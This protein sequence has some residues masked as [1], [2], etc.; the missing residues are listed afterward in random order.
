MEPFHGEAAALRQPRVRINVLQQAPN[1]GRPR[2]VA[3]HQLLVAAR[4]T[5]L[6]DA[7]G[8]ALAQIDPATLKS[9]LSAYI[10]TDAQRMLAAAGIRDEHVFP[11]PVILQTKPALLGY[12]RLLLGVPQKSF[13][14]ADTGMSQFKRMEARGVL[15][16]SQ[17]TL[18]PHL[19]RALGEGLADLVRQMSPGITQ[20]DVAELPLLTL[21]AQFQGSNNNSI[22]RQAVMDAFLSIREIVKDHITHEQEGKISVKNSAGRTV[23]IALAADPDVRIQEEFSAPKQSCHRN[24]RRNG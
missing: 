24:K 17:E 20:R 23:V 22:G 18:L 14:S 9:E 6:T 3:F 8:E 4:K 13:Y 16:E 2:Q 10:P 5:W 15:N 19:C 21:G 1:A 11:T 7:L 12:Y